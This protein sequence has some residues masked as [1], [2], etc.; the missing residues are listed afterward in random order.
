MPVVLGALFKTST[1]RYHFNGVFVLII[2]LCLPFIN[3]CARDETQP[4]VNAPHI[5][6]E[7]P[8]ADILSSNT[9]IEALLNAEFI[10]QREGPNKA[11]TPF[12]ELASESGDIKLIERLTHIAVVSQ[13]PIFIE[14]STN[15]WLSSDP[16]SETAYS[17]KLQVLLKD[18]RTEEVTTLLTNAT[19]HKV[20]LR[21]LPL[22][23]EDHVRDAEQINSLD[24][25]IAAL[26]AESQKN[27]FVQLSKAHLLLLA[28]KYQQAINTA[29]QLL[30]Q[31]NSEKTETLYL[32]LAFSQK[33]HGDLNN[34][35][36]TLQSAAIKFPNN[37]RIL[38]PL[39][40]F[41]VEN[42]QSKSASDLFQTTHLETPEKL[43]VGINL[44]RALIEHEEPKLAL[45]VADS[46]PKDQLGLSNQINYLTAIALAKQNKMTQAIGLMKSVDGALQINAINQ[47]AL[48]L[49]ED[50]KESDINNMVLQYSQRENIPEQVDNISRLHEEKGRI[51]L[52]Y[53]LINH[54]LISHPNSDTL[55][56]RKALTAEQLGDWDVTET[57]LKYLLEK[58]P[59]NPQY[60]NA[61]GYTLL[62]RTT[63][64]NEAMGYIES[65]YE[66]A[67]SDPAIIDSLGWGF[68]LK[69]EFEQSSYYLKKAWSLLPDAEIAAHYGES[70]WKQRH[71]NEAI[72]IWKTA[73]KTSPRNHLLLDT[74]QRLSP[75]LLEE[76]KQDNSP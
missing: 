73:L 45:S 38:T 50:G 8:P 49:Y 32:I 59:E 57:E 67:S 62:V 15:L 7:A 33:N 43:Q 14:R 2:F 40:D 4:N 66:K 70:L 13:N 44:M 25:A 34:A 24:K 31:D 56:Y 20:S 74:I 76:Q 28:G 75:S 19:R 23:L 26:P 54:A 72:E 10:L 63:R 22:Y 11:F 46:L 52:S 12:Y 48:W 69:G 42:K 9:D 64:I 21:F 39:V 5:S 60:L 47:V 71:Y 41:L 1:R 27:Q 61:L 30:A 17:L 36:R 3:G 68:F 6:K 18:N 29:E 51:D 55:R 35:I 53:D 58:D 37:T 65:A 16:T